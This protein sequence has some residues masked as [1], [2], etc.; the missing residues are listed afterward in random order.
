MDKPTP[1]SLAQTAEVNQSHTPLFH[2]QL[3][4]P[5]HHMP[6]HM[7]QHQAPT[8]PQVE[9]SLTHMSQP[10]QDMRPLFMTPRP[11]QEVQLLPTLIPSPAMEDQAHRLKNQLLDGHQDTQSHTLVRPL[12]MEDTKP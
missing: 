12:H 8:E 9:P 4:Q 11:P 5:H 7:Y 1:L 10:H 2:H 6:H 3:Y